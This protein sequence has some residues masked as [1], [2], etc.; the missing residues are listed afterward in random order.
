MIK[1]ILLNVSNKVKAVYL[2]WVL[3]NFYLFISNIQISS[4]EDWYFNLSNQLNHF[5]PSGRIKHYDITEF[6]FYSIAPVFLYIIYKL[7]TT[8]D[9]PN[10]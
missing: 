2:L 3:I 5:Y 1:K 7:F 4:Y 9:K 8:K 6:I 10:E